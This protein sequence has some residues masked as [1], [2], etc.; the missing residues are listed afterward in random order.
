MEMQ[1]LYKLKYVILP[2][3]QKTKRGGESK[4]ED[5]TLQKLLMTPQITR[6]EIKLLFRKEGEINKF[7]IKRHW[8][9]FLKRKQIDWH[10][11]I[12]CIYYKCMNFCVKIK[13]CK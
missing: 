13:I 6:R 3:A 9:N 1:I 5:D 10:Q 12:Y 4:R 11:S 8:F 7:V 2:T